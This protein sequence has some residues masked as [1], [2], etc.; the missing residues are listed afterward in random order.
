MSAEIIMRTIE[1]VGERCADPVPLVYERLFATH[2]ELA[3]L[4]RND[5]SGAARGHMFAT[6][7]ETLMDLLADNAYASH[8]LQAERVNHA[9]LGVATDL[10]TAFYGATADAFRDILGPDWT[11]ETDTAWRTLIGRIDAL[12]AAA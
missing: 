4:F 11:A 5:H 7:I 2:P 3:P 9:N 10:F 6:A 12:S 8:M 1:A